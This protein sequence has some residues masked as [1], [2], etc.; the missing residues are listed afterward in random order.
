M[1]LSRAIKNVF[2]VLA[3]L[4]LFSAC[5]TDE[6]DLPPVSTLTR[7]TAIALAVLDW[8]P[9]QGDQQFGEKY[10]D[11]WEQCYALDKRAFAFVANSGNDSVARIDLCTGEVQNSNIQG[12]PFVVSHIPVGKFPIDLAVSIDEDNSRVFVSNGGERSLS[13]IVSLEARTLQEKVSLSSVPGKLVVVPSDISD[14]GDVFVAYPQVGKLG[15]IIRQE[16]KGKEVWVEE[17]MATL[18]T[19]TAPDPV[20]GGMAVD[21]D[22]EFLYVADM[23]S[24]YFH[25]VDL[26]HPEYPARLKNVFGPQRSCSISPDGRYLYLSKLDQRKVAVYDL[27]EDRY[28]DTNM[29][30]PSHRN[31]P[32]PT[33]QFEYDIELQTVPR[34]VIFASATKYFESV[35]GDADS[36]SDEESDRD[37]EEDSESDPD[38]DLEAGEVDQADSESEDNEDGNVDGDE[39]LEDE[40][41]SGT[42][43]AKEESDESDEGNKLYAYAIGFN[44]N[45]QVVDLHHNLHELFDTNPDSLPDYG[46]LGQDELEVDNSACLADIEVQVYEG[47]TPDALWN[48]DYNGLIPE[49]DISVS[50]RFDFASDRFFDDNVDFSSLEE[51]LARPT[52]QDSEDGEGLKGDWL[53]ISTSPLAASDGNVGCVEEV[54]DDDGNPVLLTLEN[55]RLEILEITPDYLVFDSRGIDLEKCFMTAVSYSILAN[56]NYIVYM[57]KL[58][59]EGNKLGS[60]IYQGRALNTEF[61]HSDV[62]RTEE[63]FSS[64]VFEDEDWDDYVCSVEQELASGTVMEY[65]FKEDLK[66]SGSKDTLTGIHCMNRSDDG[67]D[68]SLSFENDMLDFYICQDTDDASIESKQLDKFQ[69]SFRT[70]SGVNQIQITVSEEGETQNRFV[71]SLLEDA[72]FLDTYPEFP[73]LY[74]VD[75][76]EETIYIIDLTTDEVI[77]YI[78]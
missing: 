45:I 65:R 31:S 35:D 3:L 17:S 33:D 10:P 21:P 15:R 4:A 64:L 37:L 26:E 51:V 14:Y 66:L 77:D 49:S 12:N 63:Q 19:Q 20:P 34:S 62:I 13:V 23:N 1:K 46:L 16:I 44:G 60:R 18:E 2:L 47:R 48:L 52:D 55:V 6:A 54:L 39:E 56:G 40:G 69:Y 59:L 76:S 36:D 24:D 72:A 53:N 32:P 9:T 68:Y 7:P 73:R 41:A 8:E 71:G 70:F 78:Q 75:S 27:L 42:L 57:T 61:R 30:L 25:V 5:S 43:M 74:V 58:D 38:G 67:E 22:G 29:E 28:V 11:Y 50:G